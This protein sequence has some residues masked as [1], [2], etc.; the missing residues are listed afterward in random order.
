M[1]GTRVHVLS[2]DGKTYK[3][4]G[5]DPVRAEYKWAT[6]ADVMEECALVAAG[7]GGRE[8]LFGDQCCLRLTLC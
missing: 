8:G 4:Q 7:K 6:Y 1:L 2:E 5:N 3:R